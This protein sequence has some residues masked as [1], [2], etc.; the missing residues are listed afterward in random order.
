MKILIF[1]GAP[2]AGK[3]TQ[4][5]KMAKQYNLRHVSTGNMLRSKIERKT[6]LGLKAKTYMDK[7]NLVPDDIMIGMVESII[8]NTSGVE[9]IILDGFPR[10]IPQAEALD[11]MLKK[12]N[13]CVCDVLF[14]NVEKSV[15]IE[16]L[17]KRAEVENRKDDS[18]FLIIENRIKIYNQTTALVI[19]YYRKHDILK[20]L[21]KRF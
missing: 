9:G 13:S 3:G 17:K 2:G 18:E 10:T 4:A 20:I 1:F 12:N 6:N 11:S 8:K 15:L 19:D 14:L 21:C 5:K 16:R 7:G